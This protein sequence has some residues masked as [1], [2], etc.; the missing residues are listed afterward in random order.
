[1]CENDTENILSS[2]I[3]E[4]FTIDDCDELLN[5]PFHEYTT[6][7][8]QKEISECIPDSGIS[9]NLAEVTKDISEEDSEIEII[10]YPEDTHH[11]DSCLSVNVRFQAKLTEA[12]NKLQD[13]LKKNTAKRDKLQK[14]IDDESR[15]VKVNEK[16]RIF[17]VFS[18]PYFQDV[19]KRSAPPNEDAKIRL[20]NI[21]AITKQKP[22]KQWTKREK[23]NLKKGVYASALKYISN[24]YYIRLQYLESKLNGEHIQEYE[25]NVLEEE[26]ANVKIDIQ[27]E[28]DRPHEEVISEAKDHID[29]LEVS[30]H[31]D[32]SRSFMEC[33]TMWNNFASIFV[34]KKPFSPEEDAKLQQLTQEHNERNWDSIAE[35]LK[36]GRSAFQCFQ[37]YQSHLNKTLIRKF[38]TPEEDAKMLKVIE[39]YRV[40]KF[41]PWNIVCN[42]LENRNVQR[43]MARYDTVLSREINRGPWTK[44]EDAMIMACVKRFGKNWRKA[45]QFLV[46][47]INCK[48]KVRYEHFLEPSFK[49]GGWSEAEDNRLIE[50]MK[51]HGFGKWREIAAEMPKRNSAQC[52]TRATKRIMGKFRKNGKIVGDLDKILP[53]LKPHHITREDKQREELK[54]GIQAAASQ[55]LKSALEKIAASLNETIDLETLDLSSLS[56]IAF[57]KLHKE[58]IKKQNYNLNTAPVWEPEY[59]NEDGIR[60]SNVRRRKEID[61]NGEGDWVERVLEAK[62]QEIND[63]PEAS[64]Y[65]DSLSS[66][67]SAECSIYEKCLRQVFVVV[68]DKVQ[69]ALVIIEGCQSRGWTSA[70]F[71]HP[72]CTHELT[73]GLFYSGL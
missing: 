40:G 46:G 48:I 63:L 43:A 57:K 35:K 71:S 49:C 5:F 4:E 22:S 61:S 34:N 23:E 2:K 12:I 54:L 30:A 36:T 28:S 60:L 17:S 41:I 14:L 64:P 21:E 1:M 26:I 44:E 73:L 47:R 67:G 11:V 69:R 39:T 24:P 38:W 72:Y 3:Q 9:G 52:Q 50:L 58:L 32:G 62:I 16:E 33:E 8:V 19:R 68:Y 10:E 37:R 42:F 6:N 31:L 15:K 45:K 66:K 70:H 56:S 7:N 29:W 55:T 18:A 20:K 25:K 51:K 59:L 27:N 65:T 53:T 13:A